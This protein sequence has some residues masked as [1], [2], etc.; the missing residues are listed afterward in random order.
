MGEEERVTQ[1]GSETRESLRNASA[2]ATPDP[3]ALPLP[4]GNA[5][6]PQPARLFEGNIWDVL[7]LVVAVA[8]VQPVV[9]VGLA[10]AA[11]RS[12]NEVVLA[13]LPVVIMGIATVGLLAASCS[14]RP[15]RTRALAAVGL[16]GGLALLGIVVWVVM[17][18]WTFHG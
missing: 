8:G 15:W 5:T 4:G 7:A 16:V 18:F 11:A 1:A 14:V 2:G 13:T 10:W 3:R 12:R 9:C 17:A 6:Q